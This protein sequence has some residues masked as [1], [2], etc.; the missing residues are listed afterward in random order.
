VIEDA[1]PGEGEPVAGVPRPPPRLVVKIKGSRT[2]DPPLLRAASRRIRAF[3]PRLVL[4]PLF[5]DAKEADLLDA[6]DRALSRDPT[7]RV[8]GLARWYV[9]DPPP[10]T[11]PK[12]LAVVRRLPQ[13]ERA[14]IEVGPV[15]PPMAHPFAHPASIDQGYLRPKP[16]GVNAEGAWN[17]PGGDGAGVTLGV[18]EQGWQ[19]KHPDLEAMDPQLILGYENP[20]HADHGNAVLGIL[21]ATPALQ[22][23]RGIASGV[24][25][26]LVASQWLNKRTYGTAQPIRRLMEALAPGDVLLLETQTLYEKSGPLSVGEVRKACAP[27]EIEPAVFDVVRTA[28]GNGIVVV[29]A[30]GNGGVDLGSILDEDGNRFLDP[31]DAAFLDSGAILVAGASIPDPTTGDTPLRILG[32][33]YGDRI[34]CFGPGESVDTLTNANGH[35]HEFGGSSSG[36]AVV[37]GAAA[38]FQGMYMARFGQPAHPHVVRMALASSSGTAAPENTLRP[39]WIGYMPDLLALARHLD[40]FAP[41]TIPFGSAPTEGRRP[42]G[43]PANGSGTGTITVPGDVPSRGAA[44]DTGPGSRPSGPSQGG[45]RRP[46]RPRCPRCGRRRC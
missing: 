12:L 34:D 22:G 41:G 32:S 36:A 26:T 39:G 9:V 21:G 8:A 46:C 27:S 29:A 13:V 42:G 14:Y 6:E 44:D 18:V 43:R 1:P 5:E 37:A 10:G 16:E 25:A 24:T 31:S 33:N 2:P 23:C 17:Q 30:A 45:C 7:Y 40:D 19:R 20:K 11:A 4:Q 38:C 3:N 28:V 15:D 35:R